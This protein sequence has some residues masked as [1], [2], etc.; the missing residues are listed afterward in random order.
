MPRTLQD[1]TA[2]ELA[3]LS[4][5]Q[6]S[7]LRRAAWRAHYASMDVNDQ[8]VAWAAQMAATYGPV[9]KAHANAVSWPVA[10][11][12][13]RYGEAIDVADPKTGELRPFWPQ[14][15]T[16]DDVKRAM[17]WLADPALITKG[18]VPLFGKTTG[19]DGIPPFGLDEEG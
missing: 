4:F 16:K 5:P 10:L 3:A 19:P 1:H 9:V 8:I 17:E 13:A 2:A 14:A 6:L 12:I 11:L 7:A 18:I 15:F